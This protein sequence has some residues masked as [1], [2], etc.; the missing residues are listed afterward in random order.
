MSAV[1]ATVV[2]V[3]AYAAIASERINRVT[4]AL[5]GAGLMLALGV[6][7]ADDAFHSDAYGIDWNVIFLL[8]GMMVIV[9]VIRETGM[10]DVL[11]VR[12]AK[13]AQGRPF[14]LLV[15][16]VL[17]T[18][19]ASALLDN[20]TTVLLVAPMTISLAGR[21]GVPAAPYLLAEAMASNIGGAAT[22]IGDP[23][24]IIIGSAAGLGYLDF[25]VNLA[26]LV[27]LLLAVFVLL[28][29]VM[30]RRSF[31]YD[32]ERAAAV[33]AMDEHTLLRDRTLMWQSLTVLAAVTVLFALHGVV[34]YEPATIAL[35][36][37]GILLLIARTN[38]PQV[39]QGVEW[40]TLAFFAGLFVM[41]G[42]L[43]KSGVIERLG[44]VAAD[45]LAG[46]V[47]TGSM[48]L[49]VSSAVFSAAVDNIPYVATMAPIVDHLAAGVPAGTDPTVLWWSLALGA[50]LGGNATPIGASANLVIIGLAARYG[51]PIRFLQFVRYGS[52]TALATIALS[53]AY[54][55]VRYFLLA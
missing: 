18:A 6:V 52:V 9:E 8:L 24:N 54:V 3:G 37:A 23:P 48:V 22:L 1:I 34:G 39:M 4:V 32:P 12:A 17:L 19:A 42:A 20:V 44:E 47:L 46:Q 14:R 31:R 55:Y 41:V 51:E 38:V 27:V 33:M 21:L 28:A 35:I 2:F 10:F 36:G 5:A 40:G 29:R 30:F 53:A 26:P 13:R 25:L 15:T 16:L 50:D 7:S 45:A 11:A 43:V 49:L